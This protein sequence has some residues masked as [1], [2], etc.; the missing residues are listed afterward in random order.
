MQIYS[1]FSHFFSALEQLTISHNG[2]DSVSSEEFPRILKLSMK[3]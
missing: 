1:S 3:P 2:F